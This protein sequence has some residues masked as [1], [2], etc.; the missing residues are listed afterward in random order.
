MMVLAGHF[1]QFRNIQELREIVKM[2]HRLVFTVV[3]KEGDVLAEIHI[4]EMIGNKTSVATLDA[5][6]KIIKEP[7]FLQIVAA[8]G[9]QIAKPETAAEFQAYLRDAIVKETVLMARLGLKT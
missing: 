9:S 2:E 4:L 1:I 7:E 6:A 3:T 8:N 5:F